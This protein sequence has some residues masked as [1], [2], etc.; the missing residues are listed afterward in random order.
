MQN[1]PS[2]EIP[3]LLHSRLQQAED[4][5]RRNEDISPAL[6][7][8]NALMCE[9]I[10]PLEAIN[11]LIYITKLLPDDRESVK[12]Y[13]EIAEAHVARLNQIARKTLGFCKEQTFPQ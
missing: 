12:M 4:T 11:N 5:L 13:M 6:C 3:T 2:S 8:A 9:V 7:Y 1:F 10:D